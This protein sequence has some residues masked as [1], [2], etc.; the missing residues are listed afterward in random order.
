MYYAFPPF[1]LVGLVLQKLVMDKADMILI[2]PNWPTQS[3]FAFLK[4]Y[5]VQEPIEI[6]LVR[7]TLRLK[8][9]DGKIY[10]KQHPRMNKMSLWACHVK[11]YQ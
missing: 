8:D 9:A 3:W 7:D 2:V 11:T 5:L 1:A 6:P 4:K 10:A